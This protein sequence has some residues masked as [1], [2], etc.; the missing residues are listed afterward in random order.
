MKTFLKACFVLAGAALLALPEAAFA[1]EKCLG[2]GGANEAT[3]NAL[4]MSMAALLAMVGFVGGG[5]GMFFVN[6]RKRASML[7][8][9]AFVVNQY[10][11]LRPTP[12]SNPD[13]NPPK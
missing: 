1:C 13:A 5:I 12:P 4:V 11:D 10:G 9:G 6:M 8:P 2:I 3:I 7:E